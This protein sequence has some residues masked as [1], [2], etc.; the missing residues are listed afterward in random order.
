MAG[1]SADCSTNSTIS[2]AVDRHRQRL[3]DAD[4]VERLLVGV[5]KGVGGAECRHDEEAVIVLGSEARDFRG[6]NCSTPST[7]PAS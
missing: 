1:M 5:E 2:L 3:A 7:S 4:V 6:R